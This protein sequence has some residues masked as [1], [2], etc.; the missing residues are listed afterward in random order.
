M[1]RQSLRLRRARPRWRRRTSRTPWGATSRVDSNG[2]VWR[3]GEFIMIYHGL[4]K[5]SHFFWPLFLLKMIDDWLMCM[6][7]GRFMAVIPYVQTKPNVH[8]RWVAVMREKN[9]NRPEQLVL[10]G[11]GCLL[12]RSWKYVPSSNPTCQWKIPSKWR[13]LMGKSSTNGECPLPRFITSW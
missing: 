4:T 8:G 10:S 5:I 2:F 7:N 11:S 9:N 1:S 13:F 6:W 3:Y 12:V